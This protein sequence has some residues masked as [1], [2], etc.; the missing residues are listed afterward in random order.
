MEETIDY[1]GQKK[2]IIYFEPPKLR[3]WDKQKVE[4]LLV[5][6]VPSTQFTFHLRRD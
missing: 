3:S 2:M 6:L 4:N 5:D 1:K